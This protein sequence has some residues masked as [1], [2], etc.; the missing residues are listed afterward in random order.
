M[1]IDP[2]RGSGSTATPV[3]VVGGRLFVP[4]AHYDTNGDEAFE[5]NDTTTR[6]ATRIL[7]TT[8]WELQ[9]VS[10][11]IKDVVT[12][13]SGTISLYSDDLA[14][15]PNGAFNPSEEPCHA[16]M[17]SDNTPAPLVATASSY[18]N[19]AYRP[20]K[21][22]NGSNVDA[23]DCWLSAA[24]DVPGSGNPVYLAVDLGVGGET[25]VNRVHLHSRNSTTDSS[26]SE[27][28][29]SASNLVAP[30][31]DN[32]ADWTDLLSVTGQP[33]PGKA[34]FQSQ[35]F[36]NGT[37]YR[38][39]RLKMTDC[40]DPGTGYVVVSQMVLIAAHEESA[41]GIELQQL[42]LLDSN[43]GAAQWTRL[44]VSSEH[45]YQLQKS[46][47]YWIVETGQSGA[48]YSVSYRRQNTAMNSTFPDE[49][50]L[51]KYTLDGGATW[52]R[53]MQDNQPA[54]WNTILNSTAD[55]APQLGYG[56]FNNRSVVIAGQRLTIPI[57]GVFLDMTGHDSPDAD[58]GYHAW[59]HD[60]S[61]SLVLAA[62]IDDIET[63]DDVSHKSGSPQHRY[64]GDVYPV[65]V[66]SGVFGPVDTKRRRLVLNEYNQMRRALGVPCPYAAYTAG[67]P[68]LGFAY[69]KWNAGDD[70]DFEALS[71]GSTPVEI[72]MQVRGGTG[73]G[74]CPIGI[75]SLRPF[76][77]SASAYSIDGIR[78]TTLHAVLPR[79][80]H[81]FHPLQSAHGTHWLYFYQDLNNGQTRE[82]ASINGLI[83]C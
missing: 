63:T 48:N 69:E 1:R 19:E 34:K 6:I 25:A 51:S 74:N 18:Y 46:G 5:L 47:A 45:R 75:D 60:N 67:V 42:G 54:C 11:Y 77:L 68:I 78:I 16:V 40:T 4:P 43:S 30:T 64:L 38:H 2:G 15:E 27:W 76:P 70:W 13:G 32:D 52:S 9:A 23:A 56:R 41:P 14:R 44:S 20:Y 31:L 82:R 22:F 57:E 29:L 73:V 55:H 66:H 39:Y 33:Y 12:R 8:D 26:P 79:G 61:G 81:R 80:I 28:T 7:P 58:F 17:T 37:P 72:V 21:A 24:G 65:T 3:D 71:D 59:L 50:N 62:T 83:R 49:G 53:C 35:G 36:V 10:R